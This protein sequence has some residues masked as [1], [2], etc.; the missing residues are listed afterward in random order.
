MNTSVI[1]CMKIMCCLALFCMASPLVRA[2]FPVQHPAHPTRLLVKIKAESALWNEIETSMRTQQVQQKERSQNEGEVLHLA[3]LDKSITPMLVAAHTLGVESVQHLCPNIDKSNKEAL[4]CGLDRIFVAEMRSGYEVQAFLQTLN[5]QNSSLKV[6]VQS[7]D[8]AEPDYIGYGAGEYVHSE[9][10]INL[11]EPPRNDNGKKGASLQALT[12]NDPYFTQQWGMQNT[13]QNIGGKIGKAGADANLPAAWSITQGTDSVIVAILD[14]GQPVGA[15]AM[16]DFA[17]RLMAGY[18]YAYNDADPTDDHGHGSNVMSIATAKGNNGVGIAGVNWNCKILPVK[19][20]NSSNS[21][22]YSWWVN[23]IRFAVD[24]GA[25]VLNMSVGGSGLSSAL[26]DAIIYAHSKGAIVVVCMMNTNNNVSYYPAAF[27]ESIAVGAIN[28][29]GAR[30]VPFCFSTTSGSN[31]GSHLHVVAPGEQVSGYRNTD[32]AVTNW[33]GTSQATPIVSGIVSLMLSVQPT[34]TFDEVRTILK[35]TAIDG[36][37]SASED[38]PGWDMYYGWGR[39]NAAAAVQAAKALRDMSMVQ[40]TNGTEP[41]V[42]TIY[43]N[44]TSDDATFTLTLPTASNVRLTIYTLLGAA[45]E[46]VVDNMLPAGQHQLVWQSIG[47]PSGVY[48]YR[49]EAGGKVRGGL[50]NVVR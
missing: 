39:V 37:G 5:T 24:K 10:T 48:G 31:F 11:E 15:A 9:Y 4:R 1:V 27:P 46:T 16:P 30:A 28:N 25:K 36:V 47:L 33:C 13:G 6:L 45:L 12:P 44:P 41:I 38:A 26:G 42:E 17:G 8:Y 18:D 50:V 29:Q 32:G 14:S 2:Q 34:L 20:L 22:Q 43:P 40:E 19:I 49:L 3:Q 23:G 7:L 21:G 35:N